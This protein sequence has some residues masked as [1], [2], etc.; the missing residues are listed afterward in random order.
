MISMLTLLDFI[1]FNELFE[2]LSVS[3]CEK[4]SYLTDM[5]FIDSTYSEYYSCC[6]QYITLFYVLFILSDSFVLMV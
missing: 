6:F 3:V 2:L 4:L 5:M 1:T